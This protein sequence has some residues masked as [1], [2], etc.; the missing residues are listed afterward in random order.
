MIHFELITPERVMYRQE[1]SQLTIPTTTGEITIL[2]NHLPLVTAL[3]PGIAR[4]TVGGRTEEIA[5]AGGLVTVEKGSRVR[6]LADS[7]ERGEELD[8]SV[9]DE[10]KKRAEKLMTEAVRQ[11]DQTYARAAAELERELA[12]YRVATRHKRSHHP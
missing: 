11:D 4:I 8:L 7:A 3:S 12:R 2:P 5:V 9:I 10:A 1:I 6:I